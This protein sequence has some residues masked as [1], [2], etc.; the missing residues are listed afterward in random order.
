M[1]PLTRMEHGPCQLDMPKMSWTLRH[2]FSTCLTLEVAVYCAHARVHETTQLW[3]VGCLVHNL[4]M[5]N[6]GDGIRF[7][8]LWVRN[9]LNARK[10][11]LKTHYLLWRED[12]ELDLADLADGGRRVRE[13]VAEHGARQERGRGEIW[14]ENSPSD[15][16]R[17]IPRYQR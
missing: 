9:A 11:D 14:V 3:F 16:L 7:L 6:F 17:S 13:L 1:S 5:F 12:S 4:W 15:E 10:R 8:L 2:P